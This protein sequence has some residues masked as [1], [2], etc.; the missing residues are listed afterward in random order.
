MPLQDHLRQL[1]ELAG[2]VEAE[3]RAACTLLACEGSLSAKE[4]MLVAQS[5]AAGI[6]QIQMAYFPLCLECMRLEQVNAGVEVG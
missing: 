3:A 4:E 2:L 6:A 1:A 5:L